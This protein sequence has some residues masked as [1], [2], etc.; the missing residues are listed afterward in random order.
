MSSE[1]VMKFFGNEIFSGKGGKIIKF[2]ELVLIVK[3]LMFFII[4]E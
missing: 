4:S 1:D 3:D 2:N